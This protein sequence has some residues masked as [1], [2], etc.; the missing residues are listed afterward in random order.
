MSISTKPQT[1]EYAPYY[2]RYVG[3]VPDGDIIETLMQQMADTSRLLAGITEDQASHRY[4]PEKWS[5]KELVGHISDS[6][7]IFAYRALRFARGDRAELA[8]FEQDGYV[9]N[10]NFD[11][12]QLRDIALEFE[13]VRLASLDLFK[14][15]SEEAWARRGVASEVEVSVKALAWIIAGHELHHKNV[16]KSKYL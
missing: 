4:A 13:H 7:R 2:E 15:L 5:V 10:G 3:L 1:T 9:A 11:Q 6:E 12:R 16:L 14:A 8:G